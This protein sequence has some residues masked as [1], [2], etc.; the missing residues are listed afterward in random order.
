[1]LAD[2][3]RRRLRVSLQILGFRWLWDLGFAGGSF[4]A[5][6][7][8]GMTVGA[9]V[10]G[11]PW[12]TGIYYRRHARVVQ[13]V[14]C[15]FVDWALCSDTAFWSQ[16]VRAEMRRLD[17]G[18]RILC[19]TRIDRRRACV[20]RLRIRGRCDDAPRP[21]EP[22][23]RAPIMLIFPLIGAVSAYGLL[24]STKRR[25]DPRPFGSRL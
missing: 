20:S 12:R 5:A 1:M 17:Q 2:P 24:D 21:D 7:V 22:V 10:E 11:F 18:A 3:A 4:V 6:F 25:N 9:L 14:R 16:L 23:A 15:A 13:P 19:V 8:Q